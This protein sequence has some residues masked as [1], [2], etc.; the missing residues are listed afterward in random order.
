VADQQD[1]A[2]ASGSGGFATC[3]TLTVGGR[4]CIRSPCSSTVKVR[5]TLVNI[6]GIRLHM[7]VKYVGIRLEETVFLPVGF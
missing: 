3:Y 2:S 6:F 4:C 5:R 7:V 1:N